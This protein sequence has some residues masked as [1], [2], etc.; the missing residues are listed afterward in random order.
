MFP[1][2]RFQILS[3]FVVAASCFCLIN[4]TPK[5]PNPSRF[6]RTA[7]RECGSERVENIFIYN[8][9][10]RARSTNWSWSRRQPIFVVNE[11]ETEHRVDTLKELMLRSIRWYRNTLSPI[12]PPNCRFVPTCSQYGLDAIDKFG[13]IKGGVL[14]AWRIARCNPF[15]GSGYD[16]PVWPPPDW[17]SGSN[18]LRR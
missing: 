9:N 4:K 6:Q 7:L 11:R 5:T 16:P 17:F 12:M 3:F 8:T 14:I 13:P 2:F 1:R 10:L 18:S 15:G